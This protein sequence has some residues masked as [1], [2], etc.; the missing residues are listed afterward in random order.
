MDV[1]LSCIRSEFA[2]YLEK[3]SVNPAIAR[4]RMSLPC[5]LKYYNYMCLP[6]YCFNKGFLVTSLK[7][8]LLFVYLEASGQ[9]LLSKGDSYIFE[10]FFSFS[11]GALSYKLF[12]FNVSFK[13][14]PVKD[15]C[16][17]R[18]SVGEIF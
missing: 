18:E 13:L 16:I 12:A 10:S 2:H 8:L 4:P 17:Y 14:V 1:G 5:V 9:K 7:L 3:Y 11:I 15:T 6:L